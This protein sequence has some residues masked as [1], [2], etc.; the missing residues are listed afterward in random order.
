LPYTGAVLI[1]LR[2]ARPAMARWNFFVRP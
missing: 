2:P 1:H